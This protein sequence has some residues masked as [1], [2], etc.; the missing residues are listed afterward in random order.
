MKISQQIISNLKK[1]GADFFLSVPCKLLA[2][3]ITI[4]EADDDIYYSA[5]PR[6]EEGMGICAGAYLGNKLP[7]IMMQ[8]TGIGNSVNSIVSLLQL[9]QMPVVFLISY[10]G[11]PGEPVGAQGG[12]AKVTEE[13]LQTLRIPMLHCSS[14][15]DLEKISTFTAHAKIIENPVAILCDFNLMK[16]D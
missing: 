6:E 8:N 16:E 12:M 15:N 9:Y 10:R 2:N 5:I 7:C 1:G 14:E 4:L 3:M 13:I 11:T